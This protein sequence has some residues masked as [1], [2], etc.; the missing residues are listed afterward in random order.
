MTKETFFESVEIMAKALPC[1]NQ[2]RRMEAL[3]EFFK[4]EDFRVVKE[5]ANLCARELDR[6][7]VPATFG[8]MLDRSRAR[9]A[10]KQERALC[11]RC[12]GFGWVELDGLAHRGRCAHG[13]LLSERIKL[14]PESYTSRPRVGKMTDEALAE[15]VAK[16]P[17]RTAKG[18]MSLMDGRPEGHTP[19]MKRILEMTKQIVGDKEWGKIKSDFHRANGP[20]LSQVT[21]VS[22]EKEVKRTRAF[23]KG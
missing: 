10:E 3:F 7:P 14:A 8:Q 5:A 6:F 21:K 18:V 4:N 15:A 17:V 11:G 16:D 13:S 20:G 12:D 23:N 22:R 1:Q 2:N 19:P 9:K